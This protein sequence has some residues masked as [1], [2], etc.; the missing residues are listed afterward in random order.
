[1]LFQKISLGVSVAAMVCLS[2]CHDQLPDPSGVYV[3]DYSRI[4]NGKVLAYRVTTTVA[5]PSKNDGKITIQLKDQDT[6]KID[7]GSIEVDKSG[8]TYVLKSALLEGKNEIK[9]QDQ[10]PCAD[11]TPSAEG[12]PSLTTFCVQTNV[13]SLF[14]SDTAGNRVLIYLNKDV[15]GQTAVVNTVPSGKYALSDLFHSVLT[16]SYDTRIATEKLYQAQETS[17][18]TRAGLFPLLTASGIVAIVEYPLG[19]TAMMGQLVPFVFPTAWYAWDSASDTYDGQVMSYKTLVANQ[20]NLVEDLY[21]D[22]L[23]DS[24]LLEKM[25][26]TETSLEKR[27]AS[28]DLR[29]R[30]GY[31]PDTD[32]TAIDD[33]IHKNLTSLGLLKTGLTTEYAS[34]STG[35]G[36]SPR[37][38]IQGL[39]ASTAIDFT[40]L[41][42]LDSDTLMAEAKSGSLDIRQTLYLESAAAADVK[43]QQW[44]VINPGGWVSLDE[45]IIHK[46]EVSKSTLRSVQLQQGQTE[47]AVEEQVIALTATYNQLLEQNLDLLTQIKSHQKTLDQITL[48]Y[49]DGQASMTDYRAEL[50]GMLQVQANQVT[51]ESAFADAQGKLNRLVWQGAYTDA[52]QMDIPRTFF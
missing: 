37:N 33:M 11:E 50:E 9:L 38:G 12:Q 52:L 24:L 42:A 32:L 43:T 18:I 16:T 13:I 48:E 27:R 31:A 1:M 47:N 10:G 25:E 26:E 29:V 17:K 49:Q 35:I 44:S 8:S 22:T 23:R 21:H 15:P 34:L 19:A 51:A 14:S 6:Q 20:M 46:V 41:K 2:G 5:D 30:A 3:G 7:L 40:T 28:I 36:L 4:E 45:S 39:V